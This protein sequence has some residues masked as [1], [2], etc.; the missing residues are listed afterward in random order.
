MSKKS[1][2]MA[3]GLCH[4]R[5]CRRAKTPRA[6]GRFLGILHRDGRAQADEHRRSSLIAALGFLQIPP[7]APELQL[8]HRWLDTWTGGGLIVVGMSHQRFQ[9]SL[10]EHGAGQWIAVFYS[11]HG[12]HEPVVAAGTTQ[13]PTPWQAVQV[14]AFSVVLVLQP[15]DARGGLCP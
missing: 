14:Y 13:A 5:T 7:R 2:D 11:G 8:L 3:C 6:A 9:V 12:G 1:R 10:G 4:R 15:Q